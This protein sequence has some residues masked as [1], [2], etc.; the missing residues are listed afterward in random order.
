MTI[1]RDVFA[2]CFATILL[3]YHYEPRAT[4]R[5]PRIP[6]RKGPSLHQTRHSKMVI[7]RAASE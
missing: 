6:L 5:N 3:S 2:I 1:L 4:T 7:L